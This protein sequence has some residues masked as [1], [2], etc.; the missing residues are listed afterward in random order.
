M[1]NK[2]L[3]NLIT[4]N[5]FNQA[6]DFVFYLIDKY[7]KGKIPVSKIK[8]SMVNNHPFIY[9]NLIDNTR[10]FSIH[11]MKNGRIQTKCNFC[12]EYL[13]FKY[14]TINYE[15]YTKRK[16]SKEIYNDCFLKA[17]GSMNFYLDF[18]NYDYLHINLKK[19]NLRCKY[20][21][22][23][24]IIKILVRNIFNKKGIETIFL[25][26]NIYGL[27]EIHISNKKT[28]KY[29]Y[30]DLKSSEKILF[31][32]KNLN[33]K[34]RPIVHYFDYF[35]YIKNYTIMVS[36]LENG[37]KKSTREFINNHIKNI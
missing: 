29:Y 15:N 24:E 30:I 2:E 22:S 28:E 8:V 37:I 7:L 19:V 16:L 12:L 23:K 11:F 32:Q 21:C 20:I 34:E 13:R 33:E 36:K 25:K 4:Q 17:K 10:N 9:F 27:L 6:E 5:Q 26:M 1:T 14:D 35:Y 31:K 3:I 18:D